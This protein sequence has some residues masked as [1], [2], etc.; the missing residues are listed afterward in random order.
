MHSF[1]A[2]EEG[3]SGQ[4]IT[5]HHNVVTSGL[6]GLQALHHEHRDVDVQTGASLFDVPVTS[7]PHAGLPEA[8]KTGHDHVSDA[9][10]CP[11]DSGDVPGAFDDGDGDY[12]PSILPEVQDDPIGQGQAHEEICHEA[13]VIGRS[14]VKVLTRRPEGGRDM[15]VICR[16]KSL[17]GEQNLV[18][19]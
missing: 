4:P 16:R 17:V 11:N 10:A 5:P 8:Q 1:C 9:E 19:S 6:G 15:D 3:V 14:R 2:G 18:P 7:G 13:V 12:G